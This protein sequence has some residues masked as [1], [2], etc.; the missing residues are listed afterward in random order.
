MELAMSFKEI[1]HFVSK[2]YNLRIVLE[3]VNDNEVI[4]HFKSIGFLGSLSKI[5][6]AIDREY[7]GVDA[8]RVR[9]TGN[10][11]SNLVIPNLLKRLS[12]NLQEAIEV[13]DGGYAILRLNGIPQLKSLL[14]LFSL[15]YLSFTKSAARIEFSQVL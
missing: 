5:R 13:E 7:D 9:F 11:I 14:E 4:C 15:N 1:E 3:R 2:K 12:A 8:L 10:L 6:L